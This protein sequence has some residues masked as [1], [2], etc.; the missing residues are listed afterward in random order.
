LITSDILADTGRADTSYSGTLQ[1]SLIVSG[2]LNAEGNP[3]SKPAGL[4][5]SSEVFF[6]PDSFTDGEA[7]AN[8]DGSLDVIAP[9]PFDLGDGDR[10]DFHG[11]ISGTT[12]YPT[13]SSLAGALGFSQVL[14]TMPRPIP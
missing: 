13:G 5:L 14:W 1:A 4:S 3:I 8:A 2:F 6:L 9:D 10:I 11:D 12:V 7:T